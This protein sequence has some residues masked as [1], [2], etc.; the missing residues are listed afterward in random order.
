[1]NWYEDGGGRSRV[2][3]WMSEKIRKVRKREEEGRVRQEHH[4]LWISTIMDRMD[5]FEDQTC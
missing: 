3:E 2:T 4:P 1:M 5:F